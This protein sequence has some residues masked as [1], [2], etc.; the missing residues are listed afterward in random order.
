MAY[1]YGW[2]V[3]FSKLDAFYLHWSGENSASEVEFFRM[4]SVCF[5]F[6]ISIFG[7]ARRFSPAQ[8][9]GPRLRGMIFLSAP[10]GGA[11]PNGAEQR[12]NSAQIGVARAPWAKRPA[13]FT[14]VLC[15]LGMRCWTA[16]SSH[17]HLPVCSCQ[18]GWDATRRR[19]GCGR[20]RGA[21]HSG[22]K[23]GLGCNLFGIQKRRHTGCSARCLLSRH[24]AQSACPVGQLALARLSL[25]PCARAGRP[26]RPGSA[27]W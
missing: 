19:H 21:G 10:A 4:S 23:A 7:G 24:A 14:S 1:S 20:Q 2:F 13:L 3:L 22:V 17:S 12:R 25:S 5:C 15:H 9:R 6:D 18:V 11:M 8:A 27:R 16:P 26:G